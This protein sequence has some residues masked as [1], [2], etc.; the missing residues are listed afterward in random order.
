M[1]LESVKLF[2]LICYLIVCHSA[3]IATWPI[4]SVVVDAV[5]G[6]MA[7]GDTQS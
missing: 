6:N 2:D 4:E 5:E 3:H 7:R 1:G